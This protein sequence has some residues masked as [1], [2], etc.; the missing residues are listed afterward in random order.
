MVE[1]VR[2]V[3]EVPGVRTVALSTNGS[4]LKQQIGGL[5]DAGLTAL[6]VSV[7]SLDPSVFQRITGKSNLD[8]ILSG[9][10]MALEAGLSTVKVNSVLMKGINDG[11]LETF[12]E[13]VRT[14]PVSIRFIELMRTGRNAELFVNCHVPGEFVR[15]HLASQ[16]WIARERGAF[17]R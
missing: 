4:R 10:D 7:D 12:Q 8:E 17:I 13:W 9:V 14:K 1:I 15:S 16:G 2:A 11:S 6:N 5:L 3:S